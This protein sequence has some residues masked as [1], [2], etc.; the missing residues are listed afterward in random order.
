[1]A[2]ELSSGEAVAAY[3]PAFDLGG[4]IALHDTHYTLTLPWLR[5]GGWLRDE[6]RRPIA[7]FSEKPS[8]SLRIDPRQD[9]AQVGEHLSGNGPE[10]RCVGR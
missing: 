2:D 6:N 3:F 8:V 5:S 1:V 10:V 9:S 7:V 4:S